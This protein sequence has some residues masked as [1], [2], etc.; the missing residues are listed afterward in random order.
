MQTKKP[1]VK[2]LK[3]SKSCCNV[4]KQAMVMNLRVGSLWGVGSHCIGPMKYS[5]ESILENKHPP[6]SCKQSFKR[7]A[8]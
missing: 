1:K 4:T 2:G 3:P 7:L 6:F 8:Y 5:I